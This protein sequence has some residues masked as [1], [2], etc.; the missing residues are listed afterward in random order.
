MDAGLLIDEL[1]GDQKSDL[2]EVDGPLD[3]CTD[4]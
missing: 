3:G 4:G 2:L 1:N